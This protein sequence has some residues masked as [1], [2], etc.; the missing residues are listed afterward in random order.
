MIYECFRPLPLPAF[1]LLLSPSS[2]SQLPVVVFVS[3][4]QVLLL[5]FLPLSAPR[6]ESVV[7]RENDELSLEILE[8]CFLPFPANT[9]SIA[10]NAKVSILVEMQLRQFLNYSPTLEGAIE[11]GVL[12]RENK[13]RGDK[14]RKDNSARTKEEENDREWLKAS[15]ERLRLLLSWVRQ[16]GGD[17]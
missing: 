2:S 14:R 6:P 17:T 15:G 12:A 5:R 9:T 10:D 11:R 1:S 4:T 7:A 3:L 13:I 16:N 8:K